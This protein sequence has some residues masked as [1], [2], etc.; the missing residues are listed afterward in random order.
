[1][2]SEKSTSIHMDDEKDRTGSHHP[3]DLENDDTFS[4]RSYH[5]HFGFYHRHSKILNHLLTFAIC[6]GLFVP[7]VVIHLEGN[8]LVLSLLYAAVVWWLLL[9]HLPTGT[10][11]R[12]IALVWNGGARLINMMPSIAVKIIGYGI[13]P[14]A[15]ILTAALRGDDSHGTRAERLISC[16]GLVVLLLMAI[17]FSKNRKAI[18]WKIVWTGVFM[19]Y[20]LAL[21]IIRWEVGYNIFQ[22]I[23]QQ[24]ENFLSYAS[25]GREFI[26]GPNSVQYGNGTFVFAPSFAVSVLPAI[27]LFAAVIQCLYYYNIV[28]SVVANMASIVIHVID[29]SGV[30]CVAACAAPFVGMSEASMLVGP[31]VSEMTEAELHQVLTSGFATI[32]GSVF[33]GLLTFGVD[34]TA[35][36]TCCMMSVPC[37]IVISKIRFPETEVP[38]TKGT[39]VAPA[40]KDRESNA[41]HAISN[42][43]IFGIKLCIVIIAVLLAVISL[44]G[45]ANGF[46]GWIF[47]FYGVEISIQKIASWVLYPLAWLIGIPTSDLAP[48]AEAMGVKFIL[49]EFAA[50]AEF[51]KISNTLNPR[52][53]LLTTYAMAS[54]ANIGSIGTQI[55]LFLT[56][57]PDRADAIARLSFSA[58]LSAISLLFVEGQQ[59]QELCTSQVC[60]SATI[61]SNDPNTIEFSLV[62]KISVGWL[63]LGIGG[64]S[65]SMPGNDLA[66]CWPNADGTGAIIS[67]RS[68]TRNGSPSVVSS[69]VAF[70]VQPAKSHVEASSKTFTCTFSRP[71]S[72]STAPI[73]STATSVNVVFAI[74]LKTVQVGAGGNP[75]QATMQQHSF[76]G[77]GALTIV[78]KKGS[79]SDGTGSTSPPASGGNGDGSSG[80][81]STS[82]LDRLLENQRMYERLV[83]AHG[84]FLV[85]FF[86]HLHHVFRWH[87]PLQVAGFLLAASGFGCILGAVNKLPGGPPNIGETDHS[88]FGVFIAAGLVMQVSIGVFIFH[89]FDPNRDPNKVH[90]PTWMHRIWGYVVLICGLLQI[91]LGISRYGMWPTGKEVIWTLFNVWVAL[92]A[93]VF[94]GGSIIKF[95]MARRR[96]DASP[97]KQ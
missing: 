26:F 73:T 69:T 13:P 33:L 38:L 92:L 57:A 21:L 62:S 2:S 96:S 87:R 44:L 45:L 3:E 54:F 71:L 9:Q 53:V 84:A 40:Y 25:E 41:I 23:S 90:V 18:S 4:Q 74:G 77:N 78:R 70:T 65:N 36:L 97:H 89:T 85:R 11:S 61:F 5:G 64:S 79:S 28:Q 76:T 39:A 43:A 27:I 42:G 24:A 83:K 75:Q 19:Q 47:H 93:I 86:S 7:A 68:A 66:I 30:E 59:S 31:F 63:G 67:Q 88:A 56:L 6:T 91:H 55:S 20:I 49:N 60:I 22:F 34:A 32:S 94:L 72:L 14:V 1:M 80:N 50:F 52:T 82:D 8:I 46:L 58:C 29:I 10:L 48:A 51:T 12:P 16:L 17:A 95:V 15:L 81:G 35:L 37:A